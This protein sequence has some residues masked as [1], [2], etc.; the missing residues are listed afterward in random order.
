MLFDYDDEFLE[1]ELCS[2]ESLHY[3][4]PNFLLLNSKNALWAVQKLLKFPFEVKYHCQQAL[5]REALTLTLFSCGFFEPDPQKHLSAGC[6]CSQQSRVFHSST[7]CPELTGPTPE[8]QTMEN[9]WLQR[10]Q[11]EI[12]NQGLTV[13]SP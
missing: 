13:F 10:H 12:Q 1:T 3:A 4:W 8:V 5:G 2:A 11:K 6:P 7:I 9:S